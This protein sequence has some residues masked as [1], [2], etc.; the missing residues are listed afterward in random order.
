MRV[1]DI[2]LLLCYSN[3]FSL[4]KLLNI[5]L[6]FS[7]QIRLLSNICP[8]LFILWITRE[9]VSGQTTFIPLYTHTFKRK[10]FTYIHET[11]FIISIWD[12]EH[13][14]YNVCCKASAFSNT[15]VRDC[16]FSDQTKTIPTSLVFTKNY[17]KYKQTAE[18]WP[19]LETMLKSSACR[20]SKFITHSGINNEI[21]EKLYCMLVWRD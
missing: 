19:V 20:P 6:N 14:T 1:V 17:F 18:V 16:S 4:S 8:A 3:M 11:I 15:P 13:E 21:L 2:V 9:V 5:I 10:F 7:S 12:T